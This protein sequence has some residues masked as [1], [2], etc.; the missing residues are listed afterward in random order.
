[1]VKISVIIPTYN[2]EKNII[3]TLYYLSRQTLP[4]KNYEIIIVDGGSKDR[5]VE[6]ALKYADKVIKQKS[7][8]V[9]GAR[10]DGAIIAKGEIIVHRCRCYC[11]KKLA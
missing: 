9:G 7:K 8:G 10:N 1:M 11:R 5:T 2:E 6:I 4:R 3:R